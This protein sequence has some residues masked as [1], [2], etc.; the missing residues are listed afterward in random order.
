MPRR[1]IRTVPPRPFGDARAR[2]EI[3]PI[4]ARRSQLR[5]RAIDRTINGCRSFIEGH[6]AYMIPPPM[7]R[8]AK[9]PR[10]PFVDWLQYVALRL[11]SMMLHSFPVD[12]NLQT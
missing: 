2:K 7:S 4:H 8:K 10:N 9:K 5:T 6:A 3:V 1:F 12:A 11:V